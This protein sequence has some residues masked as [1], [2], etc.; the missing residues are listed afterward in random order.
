MFEFK[1]MSE[2]EREIMEVLWQSG[3]GQT[4][5]G[6]L[7][8]FSKERE[9]SW[10]PQT[11]ATFMSRLAE[12]GLVK[13]EQQGRARVYSPIL[14]KSEYECEKA[15][16]LLDKLYSGSLHSFVAA[17]YDGDALSAGDIEELKKWLES[18]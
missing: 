11:L 12:K 9:R 13:W 16:T 1:E 4:L 17:L 15:K 10:K 5:N 18:K 2:T 8:Y 7:E 6:L 14:S 3:S